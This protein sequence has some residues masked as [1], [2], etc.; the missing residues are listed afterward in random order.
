MSWPWSQLGL[1]GPSG[2]SEVRHA[3]AEK[4]KTTHPEEDPEGFQRLHSA[5]QL[6]SRMARQQ[7][8]EGGA[9]Q[10]ERPPQP[11]SKPPRPQEISF[12]ELLQDG[13]EAPHRPREED[14]EQDFDFDE[15]LQGGGE[16]PRRPREGD[17]EQDF[18]FDELLQGGEEAPSRS[19][20]EEEGQDWDYERLFA[21][22]EAERA[23][24]RRRRGEERRRA[25]AQARAWARERQKANEWTRKREYWQQR[26]TYDRES[27]ERF[28]QEEVR[29]QSTE[30]ILHTLEMLYNARAPLE[31][32]KKF[33]ASP[34]FQ[35]NKNNL[36]L[37][38]GMEDFVSTKQMPQEIKLA[39]F[40]AYGFD[41]GPS[42]PEL[43]PLYQMLLPAWRESQK[44][45]VH[46]RNIVIL[47]VI[48]GLAAPFVLVP[49]LD[50]GL[51]SALCVSLGIVWI[52]WV[53]RKVVKTGSMEKRARGGKVSKKD[54]LRA[55]LGFGLAVAM[56]L[57]LGWLRSNPGRDWRDLLPTKDPRELTCRYIRQDFGVE[58]HSLYNLDELYANNNYGNVFYVGN[59]PDSR[60]FL[61]GP[62]GE[63][64]KKNGKPG[65]STN[66]PEMLLLWELRKFAQAHKMTPV[67][68]L[69]QGLERWET[70][71][72]FLITLPL[73][74]G[75]EII[76]DLGELL[77]E[78]HEEKWYKSLAQ[79]CTLVLC[80]QEM[81]EGRVVLI[82]T[83]PGLTVYSAE[84]CLGI[85]E[86]SFVHKCCAQIIKELGLDWDFLREEGEHYTLTNEGRAKIKGHEC[87]KLFGLN[88]DGA[89][90]MEY[91]IYPKERNI[92]CVPGNF[93]ETGNGEEQ[94]SFYRLLYWGDRGTFNLF[95]PWIKSN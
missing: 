75:E 74:G 62:D 2:L 32:W 52:A 16:A 57:V 90:A 41:K 11:T 25:Q 7:K 33:F 55:M 29:W 21:E 8:R 23:E 9:P 78:L 48:L 70:T 45:K 58:V 13:G 44:G 92:Y 18:D 86:E 42:Q 46:E 28:S 20:E 6:A 38:F 59:D 80:S 85:Y 91:Y 83:Q 47:G 72:T 61:A 26:S 15:L 81:E 34:L 53:I 12:D 17:G 67:D 3:Y 50:M 19:R 87:V 39:L 1:P 65:Y 71:G 27:R 4:L 51:I 95:Y 68:A 35:Q 24:A 66:L 5:Y 36:D 22:G 49:L 77:D 82:R 54:E 63:R 31:E 76:R 60:R 64:D 93:W 14:G 88:E 84:Q 30:T 43:R 79:R 94:I 10:P 89:V 40:L 73:S 69:D 37:I 56:L